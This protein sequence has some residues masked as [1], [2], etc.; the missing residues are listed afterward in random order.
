MST[1][2]GLRPLAYHY[3]VTGRTDMQFLEGWVDRR[4]NSKK[5]LLMTLLR[6]Q[7]PDKLP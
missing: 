2:S 1:L 5:A 4:V 6:E 3:K 7:G